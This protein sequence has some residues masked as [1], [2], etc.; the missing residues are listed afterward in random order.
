[1]S[2]AWFRADLIEDSRFA[3]AAARGDNIVERRE[4]MNDEIAKWRSAEI[5]ARLD[6]ESVPAA[7]VL[8][9]AEVIDDDQV[10]RN[11]IIE[12]HDDPVN[13]GGLCVRDRW[14]MWHRRE[15]LNPRESVEWWRCWLFDSEPSKAEAALCLNHQN[16]CV[17]DANAA[18]SPELRAA[19]SSLAALRACARVDTRRSTKRSGSGWVFGR[20]TLSTHL[21]RAR[22]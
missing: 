3:T 8:S 10:K 2:Q 1:M 22:T 14:G 12:L 15:A 5:L 4:I 16:E 21:E 20:D 9:R 6:R 17:G 18:W 19:R 13:P 11:G 7:P